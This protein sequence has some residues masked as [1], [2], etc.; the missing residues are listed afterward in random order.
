MQ[1][2]VIPFTY[3]DQ[4]IRTLPL[5]TSQSCASLAAGAENTQQ[6]GLA[7]RIAAFL[8][9]FAK[10][11]VRRIQHGVAGIRGHVFVHVFSSRPSYAP[12]NALTKKGHCYA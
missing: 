2:D 1:N 5:D 9:D 12:E 6:S 8:F 11:G 7:A 3:Q 10:S 4:E